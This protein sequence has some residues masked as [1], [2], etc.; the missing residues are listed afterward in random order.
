M[1]VREGRREKMVSAL[2]GL[3]PQRDVGRGFWF[4]EFESAVFDNYS[5]DVLFKIE[6][7]D[8]DRFHSY[9]SQ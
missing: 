2:C 4:L 5:I 8:K 1:A 7:R 6:V 9:F 3:L